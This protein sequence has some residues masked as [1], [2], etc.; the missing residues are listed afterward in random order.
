MVTCRWQ[1][2]WVR[3][4]SHE[5]RGGLH[6]RVDITKATVHQFQFSPVPRETGASEASLIAKRG[7]NYLPHRVLPYIPQV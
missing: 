2:L 4:V 7:V 5:S 1:D 6:E 3:V